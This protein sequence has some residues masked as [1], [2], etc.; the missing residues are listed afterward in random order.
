MIDST[1]PVITATLGISDSE[2]E[3]VA[4]RAK[5]ELMDPN[6]VYTPYNTL[7][8]HYGRKP[9]VQASKDSSNGSTD[10]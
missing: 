2:Y 8:S 10:L 4:E 6:T 5:K 9:E 3:D 1:R 7:Y